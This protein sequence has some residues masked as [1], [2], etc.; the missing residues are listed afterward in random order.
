MALA[1]LGVPAAG[2]L[3]PRSIASSAAQHLGGAGRALG[4]VLR[5]QP[6]DQRLQRL[7][8]SG[9]CQDGATGGVLMCWLMI[10]TGSSPRNG[11]RPVTIS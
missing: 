1:G 3:A 7:G 10:A 6:Q 8:Q 2:R 9:V 11:G 4:G 5:Q